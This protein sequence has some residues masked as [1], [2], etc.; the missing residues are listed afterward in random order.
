MPQ[1]RSG[2]APAHSA[3]AIWVKRGLVPR[4]PSLFD[5]DLALRGKQQPV[6]RGPRRKNAIHHVYAEIGI[7][8]DF[9]GGTDS[10][11]IAWLVGRQIFQRGLD[12]FSSERPRFTHAEAADGVSRKADFDSPFGGFFSQGKVHPT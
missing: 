2:V 3:A 10:H 5:G 6:P 8:D 7:F 1:V 12:D 11:E 9:L 4:V